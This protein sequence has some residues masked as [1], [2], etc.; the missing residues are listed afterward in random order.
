MERQ[1][2]KL[3]VLARVRDYVPLDLD[4]LY[5]PRNLFTVNVDS[6][7]DAFCSWKP[8]SGKAVQTAPQRSVAFSGTKEQREYAKFS[9]EKDYP[10]TA[11]TKATI[12]KVQSSGCTSMSPHVLYEILAHQ[13]TKN[14]EYAKTLAAMQSCGSVPT[15]MYSIT[16]KIRK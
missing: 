7:S 3:T 9:G 5:A 15:Y 16:D 4:E 11:A 8:Y 10:S 2:K 6:Q 12:Q 14:L 13:I 1:S